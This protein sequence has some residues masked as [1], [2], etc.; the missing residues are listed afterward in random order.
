MLEF[1]HELGAISRHI[2]LKEVEQL[3]LATSRSD[4]KKL[5]Q[6][7]L[8]LGFIKDGRGYLLIPMADK[9]TKAKFLEQ[10]VI[11]FAGKKKYCVI[12]N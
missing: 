4:R 12:I 11:F 7:L 5:K 9:Y 6:L 2:V 3:D 10:V 8:D 1:N